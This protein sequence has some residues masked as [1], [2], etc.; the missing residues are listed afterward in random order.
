M[1]LLFY[2]YTLKYKLTFKIEILETFK[3]F[4]S[5]KYDNIMK[6]FLINETKYFV[7]KICIK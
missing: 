3:L 5:T 7:L 2:Y 1:N 4:L 6:Y